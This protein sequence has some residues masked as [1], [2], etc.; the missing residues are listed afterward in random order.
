MTL[1]DELEP[2][3]RNGHEAFGIVQN[4][5]DGIVAI[6]RH[7][8]RFANMKLQELELLLADKRSETERLLFTELRDHVHLDDVDYVAGDG[9]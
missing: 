6:L 1:R 9:E 4:L 3:A 2:F 5:F 7:D 8:P